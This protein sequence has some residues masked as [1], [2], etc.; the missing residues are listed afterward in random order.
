MVHEEN[1]L[2]MQRGRIGRKRAHK[3]PKDIPEDRTW[4]R[5][6]GKTII[7]TGPCAR[8]F[9]SDSTLSY[10][11]WSFSYLRP[12]GT[13]DIREAVKLNSIS[14]GKYLIID[15]GWKLSEE[16]NDGKWL[17]LD[18]DMMMALPKDLN[19]I[20][21][22]QYTADKVIENIEHKLKG[23]VLELL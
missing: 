16:W 8:S 20:H 2:H 1:I 23:R 19:E 11:D 7:R 6:F 5:I 12:D 3:D 9:S 4:Y 10:P 22:N 21:P 15:N 14:D 13:T 17:L 18:G